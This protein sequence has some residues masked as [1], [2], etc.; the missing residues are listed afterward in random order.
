[1]Q[2]SMLMLLDLVVV[3]L[4]ELVHI[5]L[6]VHQ[7]THVLNVQQANS[8][9]KQAELCYQIVSSVHKANTAV[10][11]KRL[12]VSAILDSLQIQIK[13]HAKHEPLILVAVA[14][15]HQLKIVYLSTK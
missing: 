12:V 13:V 14:M 4:A 1:M 2:D 3:N 15:V 9:V 6:L 11:D 10:Q 7:Q 8:T 5:E